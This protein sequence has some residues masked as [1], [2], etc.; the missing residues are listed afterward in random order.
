MQNKTLDRALDVISE[1]ALSFKSHAETPPHVTIFGSARFKEGNVHYDKTVKLATILS[2]AGYPIMSGA[3]PGIMEAAN[4]GAMAGGSASLGASIKLPFETKENDYL[5]HFS[6]HKYFFIR[7]YFLMTKAVAIVAAAG[8]FGTLD[9]VCEYLTL[10]QCGKVEQKI[11]VVLLGKKFWSSFDEMAKETLLAEGT[12]S[13]AD[14]KLYVII[15]TAEEAAEF[16]L[17]EF[18]K[19]GIDPVVK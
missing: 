4:K 1:T 2:E 17:S 18:K 12:I 16:L 13:E 7:K 8:G 19:H 10:V 15:D 3:G 14:T 11:P 5:S 9:E 6:D